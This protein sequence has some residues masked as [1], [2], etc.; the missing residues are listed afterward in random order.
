[1]ATSSLW[2]WIFAAILL[3][4]SLSHAQTI[5]RVPADFPSIQAAIDASANG[6]TVLVSP[7]TY[8]ENIDFRG[9]RITVQSESGPEST[10]IDGGGSGTVVKFVTREDESTVIRGFTIQNGA[11]SY[12]GGGIGVSG[13]SPKILGNRIINNLG[14]GISVNFGSPVIQGNTISHNQR[15]CGVGAGAIY[16]GGS[17]SPQVLDNIISDNTGGS[18][19]GA[20]IDWSADKAVIRN[21]IIMGN[22]GSVGGGIALYNDNSS[23]VI[24]QN[25]II[26]NSAPQG[27]GIWW[28][29]PPL[30]FANNTVADNT[31]TG[32]GSAVFAGFFGSSLTMSN[33]ILAG[34]AGQSVLGCDRSSITQVST[35]FRNNIVFGAGVP[36]YSASCGNQTGIDGNLAVDPL[37]VAGD[38]GNYHLRPGSPAINAGDGSVSAIPPRDFDSNPRVVDGQI[39]IGAYE[40][41]GLTSISLSALSL[42]FTDTLAGTSSP[43]QEVVVTNTGGVVLQV[44]SIQVSGDFAVSSTCRTSTGIP[45]G[46]SCSITVRFAPTIG[47]SRSGLI[48]IQSNTS[49][50]DATIALSGTGFAPSVSLTTLELAFDNQLVGTRS[51]AKSIVLT[52]PGDVALIISSIAGDGDF[53]AT[54]NCGS[55]L[56]V[57]ASCRI[58]VT[59]SPIA[60]GP[61]NGTITINDNAPGSPHIVNASGIGLAAVIS[62][63]SGGL[64]FGNQAAGTASAPQTVM[65]SNRGDVSA[66]I[67]SIEATDDFSQFNDCG[68]ELRVNAACVITV[69]FTPT[70]RG[71]RTGRIV[72]SDDAPGTPH[73]L[74]LAG[75]GTGPGITLSSAAIQFGNQ[76]IGTSS[77]ARILTV[78][79][80][81]DAPLVVTG[82]ETSPEFSATD[83]CTGNLAPGATCTVAVTFV[84]TTVGP[85]SGTLAI[86]DSAAGSP[87]SVNLTGSGIDVAISPAS[88]NF[89]VQLVG[90]TSTLQAIL[91]NH[92]GNQLTI[93]GI[94]VSGNGFS[95]ANNCAGG[96]SPG[97]S[98]TVDVS[99]TPAAATPYSGTLTITD[100]GVGSP[101]I[102]TL[103]GRGGAPG[104]TLS[105]SSLVYGIQLIGTTSTAQRITL[106]NTGTGTLTI[107]AISTSGDFSQTNDCSQVLQPGSGCAISVT[108]TPSSAGNRTGNLTISDSAP[109][110]PRSVALSGTG[111]TSLPSPVISSLNPN[112]A[113]TGAQGFTLT[114]TGS[115]FFPA[116]VVQWNGSSRPTTFVSNTV[117]TAAI[118]SLELASF[119]TAE[120]KVFTP[121]S[122]AGI[123]NG[124][125][126]VLYDTI[127][128]AARDLIYDRF[129]ARIY[130][131]VPST[132][133]AAA[134]T[135]TTFDP[136]ARIMETPISIGS[137]P[138]KLAISDNGQYLYVAL[139]GSGGVKRLDLAT[140]TPGLEFSLG[141]D[142]FFGPYYVED[143][144]VLPQ[145]PITVA[146]SRMNRGISPRHAGVAVY[147]NGIKRSA[148]TAR[149]TGSNIL[150]ASNDPSILYGYN[151]ETTEFG[152]RTMQIDNTGIR[153]TNVAENLFGGFGTGMKFDSGRIYST[154][155][156]VVDPA[157][158]SRLG[159]FAL[160]GF[161]L[162]VEPASN[163]GLTFFLSLDRTPRLY[164]FNQQ[165][166]TLVG[167][168]NIPIQATGAGS[169]IRWGDD[170]L[171]FRA[172][173]GQVVLLRIPRAWISTSIQTFSIR[174]LG[175]ISLTSSGASAARRAGYS[176]IQTQTGSAAPSGVAIL[177][178][179]PGTYLVSETG[180]P[181][182]KALR[183]GRIY[184]EVGGVVNT[185]L[186]VANPN[187]EPATIS[188]FYTDALGTDVGSG[189]TT[190]PANGQIA[191]FID[192]APFKT[193]AGAAFQGT[194][195]FSSNVPIGAMAIRSLINERGDFLMSTLSV[196]DTA[197][198]PGTGTVVVPHFA[199]G[200]GSTTQ[201]VLVN[202]AS[203]A[204][205][206]TIEF[207]K[208]DGAPV[209]V[210]IEGVSKSSFPYLIPP[211]S[212]QKFV[213]AGGAPGATTGSVRII[214]VA[215]QTAP[216][217]Q[218][219]FVYKPREVTVSLA[220]VSTLGAT[221]FRTYV[222]SSGIA[223][224]PGNVQSALAIANTGDASVSISLELIRLDGTS[225]GQTA[226]ISLPG[227]GHVSKFLSQFFRDSALPDSFQ[228]ILRISASS[229]ISVVGLRVHYNEL[230]DFLITTTPPVDESAPSSSEEVLFPQWVDGGSFTTQFILFSGRSG[231]PS[232]G[233]LRFLDSNGQ[234][235]FL[236]LR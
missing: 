53:T 87:H 214:P 166:F 163:M 236:N 58:D 213:T 118:S 114:V 130:A 65:L 210:T 161:A 28:S 189:T 113:A 234:A 129:S 200:G 50:D 132:A 198:A 131:S 186:A 89:G 119:G 44:S 23:V 164:A 60:R 193:F 205:S 143:M 223:G 106:S 35:R 183:T 36:G 92:S 177:G 215:G 14:C 19:G 31:S 156:V 229:P 147:D 4:A 74:N 128:L 202:P 116:S 120:I 2:K 208:D 51:S 133:P 55:S 172:D 94:A 182:T 12:E 47:G 95:Q 37:F 162:S 10:I 34:K 81:G 40:F 3:T 219:I 48:T 176:R 105:N 184:G 125:P 145:N 109:G 220:G 190:I 6:D 206:G 139:D 135:I 80:S 1:M 96:L 85:R 218:V 45:A 201:L 180:F 203:T 79:S 30:V 27:G 16:L 150:A 26:G 84:P 227:F 77:S 66:A 179:R 29:S 88:L 5:K 178:Y 152:F 188:F 191:K 173:N 83:N 142:S 78:R 49:G 230:A 226:I 181:A 18:I 38:V 104:V 64:Q 24:V 86:F 103:S 62:F 111:V 43:A 72:V 231:Q 170:G 20:I 160:P 73:I 146:I 158:R 11:Q 216:V 217:S 93:G 140:R 235:T 97:L 167:S 126:F 71:P 224:R 149:H 22:K 33:N 90:Q 70:V 124:M 82:V 41:N 54:N 107:S 225:T 159:S 115:N 168:I 221:S 57:N 56:A 122:A 32:A 196:I 136:A 209:S 174:D 101:R 123:S 117:L 108:F 102:V 157:T 25:L 151:N 169:L 42:V 67:R 61:R 63:S 15:T 192:G 121:D 21:N 138:G 91:T 39:D 46:A 127:P 100:D 165:T 141:S 153:V 199:D 13:S 148:E 17:S 99:F 7:G 154:N 98:C 187:G 52:N 197:S 232:N 171:A 195:T 228:G 207:R 112:A 69:V 9:K 211:R 59:F 76:L 137:E 134:N 155:G 8:R 68:S 175:G 194:L 185:G 75:T 212:S 233:S 204:L 222:E 110:S 144:Q